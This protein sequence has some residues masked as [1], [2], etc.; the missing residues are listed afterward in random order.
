LKTYDESIAVLRRGLENAKLGNA[1]KMDGFKRLDRF[2][3][4]VEEKFQPEADFA[5]VLAQNTRSRL[6]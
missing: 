1:E 2:V 5:K 3:R 4:G 6:R